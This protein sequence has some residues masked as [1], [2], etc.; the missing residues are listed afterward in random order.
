MVVWILNLNKQ[1]LSWFLNLKIVCCDLTLNWSLLYSTGAAVAETMSA[2]GLPG[3]KW[4]TSGVFL[5][6]LWHDSFGPI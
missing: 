2:Y 5:G 1:V 6:M 3:M 4:E